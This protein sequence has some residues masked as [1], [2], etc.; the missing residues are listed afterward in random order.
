MQASIHKDVNTTLPRVYNYYTATRFRQV[1]LIDR[2]YPDTRSVELSHWAVPGGEGAWQEW[3]FEDV[4][5]Q[6]FEPTSLGEQFGPTWSTHWF[7]VNFQVPD[8][9]AGSEV[10]LRWG[11]NSEAAVW[12][13]DGS[14]LQGLSTG[15]T[16]SLRTDF[17]ITNSYEAGSPPYTLYI[18]M[19]A[20]RLLGASPGDLI[21]PPDPE[22]RFTLSRAEI[23]Q[24]DSR[25][26]KLTR[27]L[28]VL[29]QLAEQLMPD[30]RGYQAL[31]TA[32]QMV[33]SITAGDDSVA[34]DLAD[35]YLAKGNGERAHTLAAIGNCHI[36]SAWLW[37]YSET[38]RKVARSFSSQ[39]KLMEDYPEHIFV[40]S[41]AQQWS[42]CKQY[43]PE[44]FT[45]IKSRVAE[46]RFLPVGSTWVE[47]DGNIPSGESFIRQYL[48]GQKFYQQELGI[49][50]KEFWLPDTFGYSAQIPA[51]MKHV[52]LTRFLTQKLS[53]NTVNKFPH[54]SFLWE[55]I[56]GTTVLAHFPPGDSYS[57][58]VTVTEALHTVNNLQDKGRAGTSAF[59]F[60]YGD[61]GG[62]PTQDMLERARRL[63]DT[64]GCPRMQMMNPDELF[65]RLEKDQH[66][67]C[68]WVGELFLERHNGTYT[69]QA[70]MKRLCRETEFKLRDAE[71]LLSQAVA[72]LGPAAASSLLQQSLLTLDGAW[73][74]T[75][76][77]QFHDVLPGSGI[78]IIYPEA[79]RLYQEAMTAAQDVFHNAANAI[80]GSEG[81]MMQVVI[82]TLQWPRTQVVKV[83]AATDP[84]QEKQTY[85]QVG[86]NQQEEKA[87]QKEGET[88]QYI[89]VEAPS[90]GSAPVEAITPTSTVT[91]DE[92][93]GVFVVT[94]GLVRAEVNAWGQVI[95]L[96]V[97]GDPRDVFRGAD[98][99]QLVGNQL[100][101]YDDQPIYWD[102]WDVMDYHLETPQ[103]L[104]ADGSGY[105]VTPVSVVESGPLVVKLRWDVI[106]SAHSTLTQ[107]IELTAASPYLTCTTSVTW[108]ENRKFLKALF[109]TSIHSQRASF[110]IQFGHLERPTHM[111]TSW[112]SARY[113]VCGHKWA[114]LSEYDWGLAVLNNS[115][116]GWMARGHTLALS[117]L[118]SPK[119]PDD[120]ADM[121]HHTFQY[122]LLPHT[123]TLQE[124]DIV[125][126]GYEFNNPLTLLQVPHDRSEWSAASV[127]GSGAVVHTI[128]PAEDGS[129]DLVLRLYESNAAKTK[130]T[131]KVS[132]PVTSV[133][134]CNGL[135][136][137]GEELSFTQAD[138]VTSIPLSLTP[139]SIY[140][141]RIT[142]QDSR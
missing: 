87:Y 26:Y 126:R 131:L 20:N 103:V 116:Y 85:Q 40:A 72:V 97:T 98:G 110:D 108:G 31:Y 7:K 13:P 24:L 21:D 88:Y 44:L 1:N 15:D 63:K 70:D 78:A 41:Q 32:N 28:E 76:L 101:L 80:F 22:M 96:Q 18:E 137:V 9:W 25:I 4:V 34:S 61:G 66:N 30:Q 77:N 46:G 114:D 8:E 54:H 130:I 138:G 38:K 42:W 29:Y 23:S 128:K 132:W 113:E 122:A 58:S 107:D 120:T 105:T 67:L 2:L 75:M 139:F 5:Q 10:R 37:P 45:R 89:M 121:H 118:R 65:G 43:F 125:R 68:R 112:D 93:D 135:E 91:I 47:M 134:K 81:E 73:K 106:I 27:D 136:E 141:L 111:N 74:K 57:M 102:A 83:S 35:Q 55:G 59:L 86:V 19:A 53:W 62:G 99:T 71:F 82:N 95:S 100:V 12:S 69:T 109:D 115:K 11:S 33:N 51:L 49:T 17:T 36:D 64:D 104:N 94:N 3:S 14:I 16:G 140:A 117:L 50:C 92:V 124:A 60:G 129:G 127:E 48:H 133:K 142:L 119:A 123:G 56:D 6:N 39:L 79:T 84:Q 90:M 52:G